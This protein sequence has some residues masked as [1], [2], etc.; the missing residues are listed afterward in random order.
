MTLSG[1]V[2]PVFFV[3]VQ[4][5]AALAAL[6]LPGNLCHRYAAGIETTG[7]SSAALPTDA[8]RSRGDAASGKLLLPPLPLS[9]W[10]SGSSLWLP[11][12]LL[13]LCDWLHLA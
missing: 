4:Q 3:A 8:G 7:F 11:A 2:P 1:L 9:L 12:R 10:V 5:R 6:D 13:E